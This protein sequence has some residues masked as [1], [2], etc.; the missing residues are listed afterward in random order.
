[1]TLLTLVIV[2][3]GIGVLAV[4]TGRMLREDMQ[5]LLGEQQLSTA[6][7]LAAQVNHEIEDRIGGLESV[8]NRVTPALLGNTAALQGLLENLPLLQR[9]FNLG[10]FATR[11]DGTV[12][13][14]VPASS[15]RIGLNFGDRDYMVAILKQGQPVISRPASG[16]G[17]S[18]F[19]VLA[20]P[21]NDAQGN[22]IGVLAGATDLG[23]PNFMDK[24]MDKRYGKTG[25]YFLAAPQYRLNI[26]ATD[27]SRVMQA[28]P[29]PGIS[30][31]IDRF[32]QGY[33]GT[34]VYVNQ[35]GVEV[36]VSAR[37]V[38][39]AGWKM[40][41]NLPTTEAFAPIRAMQQNMLTAA[42]VISLLAAVLTWWILRRQ[43]A[44]LLATVETLAVLSD[45][46]A[47]RQLM[48]IT[49]RD[50]VGRLIG[51]F[52]RLLER[53]A[54]RDAAL[55]ESGLALSKHA[56]QLQ[57]LSRRVMEVQ[58][59]E[60]R[61]LAIE[62]HDELGQALT[63]IKFNLQAHDR[64]NGQTP[65]EL[66]AEN[67]HIVEAAL[68]QVRR[69]ALALRP[70]MLDDLGLVPALR[71]I[72]EQTEARGDLVVRLQATK[73]QSRLTPEVETVCFRIVQE[74]LT[75]ILRHAQA[76]LVEI[77]V[78]QDADTLVLCVQDDGCGFDPAAIQGHALAVSSMGLLGMRE[79]ATLVGGQLD[80]QSAPGQGCKVRLCCP[81]RK[82]DDVI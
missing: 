4:H 44:P 9:M 47:P 8:S 70:S 25:G 34:L 20:V 81:L 23:K 60:R 26:A 58:E 31:A 46:D 62:L 35:L 68:Q 50:E 48:P 72:A 59:A 2:L 66:N 36:L 21:I 7:L 53:I 77:E 75:N 65:A 79:R 61:R 51:G 10:V 27:K 22:M 15:G 78:S 33:E 43:L 63:A 80:V 16:I 54:Q 37:N 32:V 17:G 67:I 41:V 13:A 74:S 29:A 5:R 40:V 6:S 39:A 56:E 76:R 1:M 24:I 52:N 38:P 73:L 45:T 3:I 69:L 30:P 64:L 11:L 49:S 71:W 42:I 18:P 19:F 14:D 82:H 12:I 28:L 57:A 55:R